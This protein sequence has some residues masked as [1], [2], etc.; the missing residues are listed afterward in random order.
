MPLMTPAASYEIVDGVRRARAWQL[1]GATAVL[2]QVLAADG[3]LGPV[4][5]VPIDQ[6]LSPKPDIDLSTARQADRFWNIWH[7][8]RAGR[9]VQLPPLV[10]T[11]GTRG[12]RLADLAWKH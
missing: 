4:L 10:I 9:G 3:T 8:I 7:A 11:P 12:T 6:L 1:A 2:A 5:A